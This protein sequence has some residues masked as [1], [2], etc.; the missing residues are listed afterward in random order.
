MCLSLPVVV[1]PFVM[2]FLLIKFCCAWRRRGI[3]ISE[4]VINT[5]RAVNGATGG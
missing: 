5:H 1:L 2:K 3:E 4:E